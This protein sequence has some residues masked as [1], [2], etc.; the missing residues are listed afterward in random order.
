MTDEQLN[1]K[2]EYRQN[3]Q[4]QRVLF[5]RLNTQGPVTQGDFKARSSQKPFVLLHRLKG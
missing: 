2:K 4:F 3:K 1:G 5:V